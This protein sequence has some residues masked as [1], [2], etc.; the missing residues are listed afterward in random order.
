MNF[1]KDVCLP[2]RL[3]FTYDN[4]RNRAKKRKTAAD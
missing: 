2:T 3:C 4:S 1:N